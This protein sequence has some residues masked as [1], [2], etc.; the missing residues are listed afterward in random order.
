MPVV[1]GAPI[2][3]WPFSVDDLPEKAI[4]NQEKSNDDE[5][6]VNVKNLSNNDAEK[7]IKKLPLNKLMV[8]INSRVLPFD[9]DEHYL[10]Y[11][12]RVN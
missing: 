3:F 6:H 2:I 7:I 9:F 11:R 5:C 12:D 10:K 4:F 1:V 8:C